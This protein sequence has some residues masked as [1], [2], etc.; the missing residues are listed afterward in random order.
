MSFEYFTSLLD[1]FQDLN[2]VK[3]L[4]GE[5]TN[6]PEFKK[7]VTELI[8]RKIDYIL[9]TNLL[10]PDDI[11]EFMAEA[12]KAPQTRLLINSTD[13]DVKDRIKVWSSN[14]NRIY[15][16]AYAVNREENLTCGITFD[17]EK[18]YKYYINYID[19]LLQHI[20]KIEY[21]RLSLTFPEKLDDKNQF[22]AI[23]NKALGEKMLIVSRKIIDLNAKP[24]IDCTIY[25]CMFENKEE[26]KF[27]RKFSDSP[28]STRCMNNHHQ[29]LNTGEMFYCYPLRGSLDDDIIGY[30]T[31]AQILKE[32]KRR[33]DVLFSMVEKPEVCKACAFFK[34]E[35]C[36]GPCLGFYDLSKIEKPF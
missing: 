25:P 9:F 28:I 7:F 20:H 31:N 22:Y 19:F 35:E 16:S 14:Y 17:E 21:V 6:H 11:T 1:K 24:N 33:Y 13:I 29:V 3:L 15:E 5:P 26:W 34:A 12:V 30:E 10:F 8:R 18:D 23:N 32:M 2:I 4:G 27:L 36:P